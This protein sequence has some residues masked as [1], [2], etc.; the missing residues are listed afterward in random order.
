MNRQPTLVDLTELDNPHAIMMVGIPGSGKTHIANQIAELTGHQVLSSDEMRRE[1]SG[2]ATNQA[3]SR[4]AWQ[5]LFDRAEQL[6]TDGESVIID[7][8]NNVAERRRQ[9]IRRLRQFGA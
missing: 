4:Q 1:L 5:L 6:I 9:D 2:D 3:V 7:G 8:T